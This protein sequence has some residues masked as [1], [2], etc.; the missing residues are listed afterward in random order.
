MDTADIPKWIAEQ[1]AA[2]ELQRQRWQGVDPSR[3]L[4]ALDLVEQLL[5]RPG[6]AAAEGVPIIV[7]D[8]KFAR[9]SPLD[10]ALTSQITGI[11]DPKV[12]ATLNEQDECIRKLLHAP[13][14]LIIPR[15]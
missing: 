13:K 3:L 4:E 10:I 15:D 9:I 2:A 7:T 12:I 11:I 6:G 14:L 5:G 8:F 1:R